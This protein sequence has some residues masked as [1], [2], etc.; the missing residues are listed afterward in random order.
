MSASFTFKTSDPW[1]STRVPVPA[2]EL[3]LRE[4]GDGP[5]LVLLHGWPQHAGMWNAVGGRLAEEYRVLAPDLRG[6]GRSQAPPGDY[7]KHALAGDILALLD[8]LEI[9]R[10]VLVGHDWGGWI[11]WLLALEHP[12]RVERFVSLDVPSPAKTAS[13]PARIPNQL[14]YGSYQFALA[15][16]FV[17]ERLVR[18][19]RF[20]RGF[21]EAGAGAAIP[22]F[23]LDDYAR[24]TAKPECARASVALYRSFL[25]RELPAV[26]RG[27]YTVDRLTLPGMVIMGGDSPITKMVGVSAEEPNLVVRT[28][29][30]TGHFI[31]DEAPD[32]TL[33]LVGAFLQTPKRACRVA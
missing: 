25:L 24:S 6:F 29:P 15:A 17:G 1:H 18:S 14:F 12:E 32:E 7:S 33:G 8:R 26:M 13:S 31:V 3:H 10:A 11:A 16:P 23:L 28:V 22:D 19:T 21:I 30:G 4:A 27:T 2:A 9:E 20:V 5:P